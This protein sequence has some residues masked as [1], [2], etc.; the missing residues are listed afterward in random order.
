MGGFENE[1]EDGGMK[2]KSDEATY[3][4]PQEV[5]VVV[6]QRVVARDVITYL[7]PFCLILSLDI[8]EPFVPHV[9]GVAE[10]VANDFANIK[11]DSVFVTGADIDKYLQT[12]CTRCKY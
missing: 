9:T 6:P 10:Y 8:R 5:R 11:Y 3:A 2:R 1:G 4:C 7:I 12:I